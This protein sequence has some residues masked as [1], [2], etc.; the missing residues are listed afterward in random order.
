MK[1]VSKSDIL[2]NAGGGKRPIFV[3]SHSARL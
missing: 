1:T 3:W 2:L